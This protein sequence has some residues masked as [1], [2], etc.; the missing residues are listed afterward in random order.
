MGIM[1]M[2]IKEMDT[3]KMDIKGGKGNNG[4]GKINTDFI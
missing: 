2:V 1:R 4:N 3:K